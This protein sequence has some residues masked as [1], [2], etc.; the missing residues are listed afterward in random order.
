MRHSAKAHNL[1]LFDLDSP[2]QGIVHVISPELGIV[3]PGL[4][5]FVLIATLVRKVHLVLWHGG[6]Y[7][8]L[9]HALATKTLK[10]RKPKNM[11]I[12]LDGKWLE[13]VS[14]KDAI[15]AIISNMAQVTEMV[16]R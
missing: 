8:D 10:L 4:S 7:T 9:E 12:Y 1:K 16:L 2:D 3:Q 15:L 5:L 13:G 14:A 11:R 6:W